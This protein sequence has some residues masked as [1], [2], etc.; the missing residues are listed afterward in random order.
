[1]LLDRF[2]RD[3]A[4][5][6]DC[7]DRWL[8]LGDHY[9]PNFLMGRERRIPCGVYAIA[10]PG[11]PVTVEIPGEIARLNETF[12]STRCLGNGTVGQNIWSTEKLAGFDL[13][14]LRLWLPRDFRDA[15]RRQKSPIAKLALCDYW[16][17]HPAKR[18]YDRIVICPRE[19]SDE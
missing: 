2:L 10:L 11:T 8:P 4:I 3:W 14:I 17:A 5:G 13:P 7:K 9:C 16:W 18:H 12:F 1:M 19:S 15:L 6:Q